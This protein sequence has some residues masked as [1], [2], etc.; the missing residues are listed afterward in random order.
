[1][2]LNRNF[3]VNIYIWHRSIIILHSIKIILEIG[4]KFQILFTIDSILKVYKT[5]IRIIF[6]RKK[7]MLID[8]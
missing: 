5:G 4:E 6:V 2:Q 3:D 8:I 7:R 1:M